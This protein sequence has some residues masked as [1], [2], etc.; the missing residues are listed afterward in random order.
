MD[1]QPQCISIRKRVMSIEGGSRARLLGF[2]AT[3]NNKITTLLFA[4]E[5]WLR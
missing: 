3:D 2:I 1:L 4:V 5:D